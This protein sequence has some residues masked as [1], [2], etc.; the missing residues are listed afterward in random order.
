MERKMSKVLKYEFIL[1]QDTIECI[2]YISDLW[3]KLT[4]GHIVGINYS[5]KEQPVF[6]F[7]L[8]DI[9]TPEKPKRATYISARIGEYVHLTKN[10]VFVI[11]D[12]FKGRYKEIK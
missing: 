7:Y 3:R 10:G 12:V 4:G 2:D 8:G 5:E 11:K 1:L 6:K 9:G